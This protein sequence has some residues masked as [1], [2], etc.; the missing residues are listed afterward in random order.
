MGYIYKITNLLNNKVYIGQTTRTIQKRF[1]E[2]VD[3]YRINTALKR[4]IQKYGKS[5]FCIQELE[6]CDNSILDQREQ[7]W[8]AVFDAYGKSGYN[9]TIGGSGNRKYNYSEKDF[10]EWIKLWK[11]GN[12]IGDISKI[13]GFPYETISCIL[14]SQPNFKKI[15]Q[16]YITSRIR[17]SKGVKIIKYDLD[18][19]YI[20]SFDTAIDA[21]HSVNINNSSAIIACC[22]GKQKTAYGY[23]WRYL[24][25]TP[26]LKGNYKTT[27]ALIQK[28]LDG[29]Y[30]RLFDSTVEASKTLGFSD[31]DISACCRGEQKTAHGY[32][33]EYILS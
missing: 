17:S 30:I 31:R 5:N 22:K 10:Q 11:D 18:C 24:N 15:T 8:I 16:S 32:I 25:S 33:F 28:D 9:E 26:P 21:A 29:N 4:A 2:H 1:S 12:T 6:K 3:E 7:Y 27:K 20:A 23:I 19:K 13:T 14:N